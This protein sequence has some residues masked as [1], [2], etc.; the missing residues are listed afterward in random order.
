MA[1]NLC[2]QVL[3]DYF[4]YSYVQRVQSD[5]SERPGRLN[6]PGLVMGDD[7]ELIPSPYSHSTDADHV[8]EAEV[9]CK[10]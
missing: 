6:F 7:S 2:V 9:C 10:L 4:Q 8:I 1:C 5:F 3:I